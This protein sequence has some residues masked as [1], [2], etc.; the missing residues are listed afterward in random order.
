MN[1]GRESTFASRKRCDVGALA[2]CFWWVREWVYVT[3]QY[4]LIQ[5]KI[6]KTYTGSERVSECDRANVNKRVA[7]RTQRQ[8]ANTSHGFVCLCIALCC[9]SCDRALRWCRWWWKQQNRGSGSECVCVQ[10]HSLFAQAM[11]NTP[12]KIIWYL[13]NFRTI[14]IVFSSLF[15]RQYFSHSI[16]AYSVQVQSIFICDASNF[17]TLFAF[18]TSAHTRTTADTARAPI[19]R[20]SHFFLLYCI[21]ASI[22]MN[23]M[24]EWM[25]ARCRFYTHTQALSHTK[26]KCDAKTTRRDRWIFRVHNQYGKSET[27]KHYRDLLLQ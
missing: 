22:W 27:E 24:N 25:D 7:V 17:P 20:S 10:S 21:L 2:K 14:Q 12:R 9:S 3:I 1:G 26:T 11:R 23:S 8:N 6:H 15:A 5:L 16:Q 18:A 19:L 13:W 4:A